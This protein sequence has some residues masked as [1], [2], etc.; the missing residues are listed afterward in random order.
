MSQ[1]AEHHCNELGPTGKT[2]GP[3][4]GFVL[5]HKMMEFQTGN[6]FKQ[7][8]KQTRYFYHVFNP[9]RV[10]A[11]SF[12]QNTSYSTKPAGGHFYPKAILDKSGW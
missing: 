10:C 3:A 1:M 5:G 7:L 2:F 11:G 6:V 9:P 12:F 8:T 4:F